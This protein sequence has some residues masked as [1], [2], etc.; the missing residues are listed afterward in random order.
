MPR[1][2]REPR[3][4]LKM[5]LTLQVKVEDPEMF[6]SFSEIVTPNVF[7]RPLLSIINTKYRQAC[8]PTSNINTK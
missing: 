8:C 1:E 5:Y 2:G 4:Q 6:D 3:K 7:G